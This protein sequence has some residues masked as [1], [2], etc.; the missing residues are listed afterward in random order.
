M[1]VRSTIFD[2]PFF[3]SAIYIKKRR[4]KMEQI[5][6]KLDFNY[7]FSICYKQI[8]PGSGSSERMLVG[9]RLS[10]SAPPGFQGFMP[11]ILG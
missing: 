11:V 10:P 1:V 2:V 9:V 7:V 4:T 8:M 3:Y 5:A 6:F